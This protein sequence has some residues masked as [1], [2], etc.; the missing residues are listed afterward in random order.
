M[1]RY[2]TL[3]VRL[4]SGAL[5]D[6]S[7]CW[8]WQR[9]RSG[10]GYGQIRDGRGHQRGV[11][12]LA[13]ELVKGPIPEGLTIDHLCRVRLCINPD[14]LEAVT[15]RENVMRGI[16][17]TAINAR[18]THCAQGHIYSAANTYNGI[19]THTG[20][21]QCRKCAKVAAE[22]SHAVRTMKA[23]AR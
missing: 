16:G 15:H 3:P 11:H 6:G 12:R 17:P 22:A 4:W 21:R 18:K 23:L 19:G 13:Y 7:G 10:S 5:A 1:P 9:A 2:P 20:Q 14:H 8:V